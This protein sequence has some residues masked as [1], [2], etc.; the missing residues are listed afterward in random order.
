MKNLMIICFALFLCS[1]NQGKKKQQ[2]TEP[3]HTVSEQQSEDFD[4]LLGNWKRLDEELGKATFENWKK[5]NDTE[6]SGIGFTKQN[7]DTI[8]QELIQLIKVNEAW[9]LNV[10]TPE[11]DSWTIFEGIKHNTDS[12]TCENTEIE[13]PNTIKYWINGTT[14]HAMVSGGDMEISFEFEK[15]KE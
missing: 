11:E 1:C 7:G 15:T 10:K 13:F 14:L 3:S 5:I 2:T 12:F 6:Y 9:D 4:W 8:S